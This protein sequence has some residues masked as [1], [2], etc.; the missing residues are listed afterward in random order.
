MNKFLIILLLITLSTSKF[1]YNQ[2]KK[3]ICTCTKPA[4]DLVEFVNY[5]IGRP[6]RYG[7]TKETGIDCSAFTQILYKEVLLKEI[8]RTAETQYKTL[9]VVSKSC[10]QAGDLIFFKSPYSPSGWHVG[11]YLWEQSFIH[12]A[13]KNS[14]VIISDLS[15]YTLKILGYRR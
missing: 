13:G 6:Y 11:V 10:L 12:S 14:G 5:W 4:I 1:S 7:G 3:E 8:P 9:S 2:S 15:N